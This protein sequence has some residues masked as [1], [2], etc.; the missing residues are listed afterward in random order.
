[1]EAKICDDLWFLIIKYVD[2]ITCFNITLTCKKFYNMFQ[3][4]YTQKLTKK[5]TKLISSYENEKKLFLYAI[6]DD[7]DISNE[8]KSFIFGY[9]CIDN[10]RNLYSICPTYRYLTYD[11][12]PLDETEMDREGIESLHCKF[13]PFRIY[14]KSN[15][16]LE[17]RLTPHFE[18]KLYIKKYSNVFHIFDIKHLLKTNIEK[19]KI[20]CDVTKTD[21]YE[22]DYDIYIYFAIE[23]EL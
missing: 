18:Y 1:M 20:F 17:F 4:I 22:D 8:I 21:I 16:F 14:Y 19:L 12:I 13:D 9:N 15:Y 10:K 11:D 6:K 5:I 23:Y 7:I 2:I 3:L